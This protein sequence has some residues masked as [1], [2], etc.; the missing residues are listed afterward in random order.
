MPRQNRCTGEFLLIRLKSGEGW[1][2]S[3]GGGFRLP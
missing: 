1:P 2:Q 3:H